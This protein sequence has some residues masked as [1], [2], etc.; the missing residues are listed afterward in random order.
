MESVLL[1]LIPGARNLGYPWYN[2]TKMALGVPFQLS[3][4]VEGAWPRL[5]LCSRGKFLALLRGAFDQGKLSFH[6]KFAALAD[7][8]EFRFQ[9]AARTAVDAQGTAVNIRVA[10]NVFFS[11]S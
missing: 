3:I 1:C 6:G 9:L 7:P 4:S 2:V 5:L 8:R 11:S 10:E